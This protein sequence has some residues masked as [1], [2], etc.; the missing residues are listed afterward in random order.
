ME[1]RSCRA[2]PRVY[3]NS[4][5]RNELARSTTGS[6]GVVRKFSWPVF[7]IDPILAHGL[8]AAIRAR[9]AR[10]RRKWAPNDTDINSRPDLHGLSPHCRDAFQSPSRLVARSTESAHGGATFTSFK[11]G[12]RYFS[13]H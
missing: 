11:A 5:N 4:W 1:C 12:H 3:G 8:R 13:N 10:G 9:R 7:A 2:R 6:Q